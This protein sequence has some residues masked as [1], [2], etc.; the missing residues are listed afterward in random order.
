MNHKLSVLIC[1]KLAKH[2]IISKDIEEVY[3]YGFELI[4]SFLISVSIILT[5]GIFI[6]K[7]FETIVF[8]V[9]FI[10]SDN[11]PV[12]FTRI[13]MLNVKYTL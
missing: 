10:L 1:Q 2:G 8:L 9:L 11:L 7:I 3:I 5:I 13:H 4:L 12:V 6:T